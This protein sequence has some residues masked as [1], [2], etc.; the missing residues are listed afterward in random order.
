[1]KPNQR[2]EPDQSVIRAVDSQMPILA[3]KLRQAARL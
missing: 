1:M 2:Q 3:A